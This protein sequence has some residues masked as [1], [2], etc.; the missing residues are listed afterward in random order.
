MGEETIP[1]TGHVDE[2]GDGNCDVCGQSMTPQTEDPGNGTTT[3]TCGKCGRNHVG[4]VGGF[5]GGGKFDWISTSRLKRGYENIRDRY[6]GWEPDALDKAS[7]FAFVIVAANG[8]KRT[9]VIAAKR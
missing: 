6:N 4:K 1:A 8:G 3:G 9:N 5:W 2:N 7:E